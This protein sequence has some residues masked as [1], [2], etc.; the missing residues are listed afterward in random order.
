MPRTPITWSSAPFFWPTEPALDEKSLNSPQPCQHG[1]NCTYKTP[2][3]CCA[4]VHPGEQGSGR[5][6]FPARIFVE[7][8]R[9]I[10]Q[11]AQVRLIGSSFYERRSLGLSWPE[12]CKRVQPQP[13]PSPESVQ[14]YFN[15]M[16]QKLETQAYAEQ[17]KEAE[18]L[19]AEQYK[20][21]MGNMLMKKV[22][23]HLDNLKQQ[24]E[25]GKDEGESWPS[26]MSAG[27]IVG[28]FLEAMDTNELKQLLN[29]PIFFEEK[30]SEALQILHEFTSSLPVAV[31][32]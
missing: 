4:F 2:G 28:M 20:Q 26:I 25:Y 3:K 6:L 14:A 13:Q 19:L 24:F 18:A 21:T 12:W 15:E 7:N 29:D 31:L 10:Y 32:A 23:P 5:Q 9:Q 8:G 27:K 1:S 22:T 16:Y 17:Q 30:F 11:K